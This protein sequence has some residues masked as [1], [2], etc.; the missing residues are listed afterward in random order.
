M[1]KK[2]ILVGAGDF[3]REKFELVKDDAPTVAVDGGYK[4]V[5]DF[6]KVECVVGDF[7]S[8]GYFPSK[9]KLVILD[10][11]KDCTDMY[12]AIEH[13]A[14]QDYDEFEIFGGLG[15]RLDHTLANLQ[16]AHGF[17]KKGLNIRFTG[18]EEEI[19]IITYDHYA[20]GES[21]EV[22]SIFALEECKGVTIQNAKYTLDRA[23]LSPK[24]PLGVSNEFTGEWC[25]IKVDDGALAFVRPTAKNNG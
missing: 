25:Y 18:C 11:V 14:E 7:D 16:T 21:G 4:Y 12:A 1:G 8:L 6:V 9:E 13:M 15:G 17:A 20:K 3:C 2:C 24:F 22:F 10:P 5:E 23:T 19:D